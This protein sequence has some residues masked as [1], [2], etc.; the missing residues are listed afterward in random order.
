MARALL[1]GADLLIV[2]RALNGVD[3]RTQE[4]VT[5]RIIARARGEGG[6]KPF[7]LFWVV[8]TPSISTRFDRVLVFDKQRLSDDGTPEDL[9]ETNELYQRL[10]EN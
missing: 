6:S 3:S 10:V 5:D 4:R 9:I 1:K 2:N 7:G 8:T